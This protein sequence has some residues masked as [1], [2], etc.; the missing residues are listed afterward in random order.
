MLILIQLE[1]NIIL[2]SNLFAAAMVW[3]DKK[4]RM[5]VKRGVGVFVG[6][7][8]GAWAG[9]EVFFF[10]KNAVLGLGLGLGL[11]STITLTLP[12]TLKQYFFKKIEPGPGPGPEPDPAFYWNP[13]K[14][15]YRPC[16]FVWTEYL[17]LIY[18]HGF[19]YGLRM[20]PERNYYYLACNRNF[21]LSLNLE[22]SAPNF[23]SFWTFHFT[24][25]LYNSSSS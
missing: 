12:L 23:S 11:V 7:R 20:M 21:V 4:K 1:V 16:S 19:L 17:K 24:L 10:K 8:A 3:P 22:F 13:I 14:N 9:F 2:I 5:L 15:E 18:R 25:A 6:I